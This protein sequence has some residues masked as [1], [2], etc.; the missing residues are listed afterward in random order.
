MEDAAAPYCTEMEPVD[1]ITPPVE[2]DRRV[3]VDAVEELVGMAADVAVE[4]VGVPPAD[5]GMPVEDMAVEPVEED[6]VDDD[7]GVVVDVVCAAGAVPYTA[8]KCSLRSGHAARSGSSVASPYCPDVGASV[9]LLQY[10][11]CVA[12]MLACC[13][14]TSPDMLSIM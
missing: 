11:T 13:D 7:D 5:V 4:E 9:M 1:D 14:T 6:A 2:L 8:G 12:L 10:V 3:V